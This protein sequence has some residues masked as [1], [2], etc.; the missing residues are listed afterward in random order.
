MRS[1][2]PGATGHPLPAPVLPELDRECETCQGNG[3]VTTPEWLAWAER[4]KAAEREWRAANPGQSWFSSEA[5]QFMSELQPAAE[6]ECP[7]CGGTGYELTEAGR[8]LLRFLQRHPP[9]ITR[10]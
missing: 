3:I 9:A 8:E 4:E 5:S 6:D 2:P 1:I 10:T 7:K